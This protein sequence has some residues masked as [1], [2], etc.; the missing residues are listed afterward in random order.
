MNHAL[1]AFRIQKYRVAIDFFSFAG[2]L[3]LLNLK[4]I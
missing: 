1:R 2:V 4:A 3:A